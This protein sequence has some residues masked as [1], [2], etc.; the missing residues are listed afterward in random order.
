MTAINEVL[1]DF[2][3]IGLF[4]R[5]NENQQVVQASCVFKIGGQSF[6]VEHVLFFLPQ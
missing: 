2:S 3:G 5:V 6:V 4:Q 1:R